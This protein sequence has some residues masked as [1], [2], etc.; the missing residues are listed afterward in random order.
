VP[1]PTFTLRI[2]HWAKVGQMQTGLGRLCSACGTFESTLS[3]RLCQMTHVNP[4][5]ASARSVPQHGNRQEE[6]EAD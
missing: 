3:L 2:A 1:S 4:D 6:V 5:S